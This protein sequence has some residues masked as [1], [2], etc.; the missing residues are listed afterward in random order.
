MFQNL[1][2]SKFCVMIFDVPK[3]HLQMLTPN[4]SE[5]KKESCLICIDDIVSKSTGAD[6]TPF[7]INFY[8]RLAMF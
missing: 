4:R 1:L 5:C 6:P 7:Y 8:D 2:F 3:F